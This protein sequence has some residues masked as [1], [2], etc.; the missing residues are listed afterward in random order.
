MDGLEEIN[1][2]VGFINLRFVCGKGFDVV[3]GLWTFI[4]D[5][6]AYDK[7]FAIMAMS[8][9]GQYIMRAADVPTTREGIEGYYR[10]HI[11]SNNVAGRI[12]IWTKY[13]ISQTKQQS[14]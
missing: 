5:G 2:H 1:L 4:T 9:D 11:G 3:G 14:T 6:Q 8:G 13:S 12:K 7:P 10:H